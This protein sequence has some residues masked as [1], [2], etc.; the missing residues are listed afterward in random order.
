MRVPRIALWIVVAGGACA[1]A[2]AAL[3]GDASSVE[4]DR[5]SLRGTLQVHAANGYSV[6]E[7]TTASGVVHEYLNAA[8]KVFAVSW[9]GGRTPDL[10]QML[11]SSYTEMQQARG[12]QAAG[13]NHRRLE[14]QTPQLVVESTLVMRTASGRAWLPAELPANFSVSAIT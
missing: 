13:Y 10:K 6:H 3:G 12:N 9:K 1:P 14:V 4:A 2:L 11:G 7:I 5:A 8:G